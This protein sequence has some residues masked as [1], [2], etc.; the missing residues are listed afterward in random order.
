MPQITVTI[1]DRIAEA[2]THSIVCGRDD[3][4]LLIEHDAEWYGYSDKKIIIQS[5]YTDGTTETTS[6]TDYGAAVALPAQDDAYAILISYEGK[7]SGEPVT[8]TQIGIACTAAP[9]AEETTAEPGLSYFDVYNT[10]MEYI[11]FA[12]HGGATREQLE[13]MY[14]ALADHYEN[15][16][17]PEAFPSTAYRVAIA[18]PIR[19]VRLTG[20]ITLTDSTVVSIDSRSI[21]ED[22][23]RINAECMADDYILP[24]AAVAKELRLSLLGQDDPDKIAGARIVLDYEI[25]LLSGE[26]YTVPLGKFTVA[27]IE[28]AGDGEALPIVAYDD[29]YR[30]GQIE[31][32][33]FNAAAGSYY[34]PQQIFALCAL[35][36]GIPYT[37]DV[38]SYLNGN[39]EFEVAAL[40]ADVV[41]LRDLVMHTAQV[42]C[43]FAE[44]DRYGKLT[45]RPVN[46]ASS[47]VATIGKGQRTRTE[48]ERA[49]Y[50]LFNLTTTVSVRVDDTQQMFTIIAE[51]LR[52]K[53]IKAVMP[54]NPLYSVIKVNHP[55]DRPDVAYACLKN[56]VEN[57]IENIVYNPLSVTLYGD[58]AAELFERRT[59]TAHGKAYT[60]P[61]TAYEWAFNSHEGMTACGRDAIAG[62]ELTQLEKQQNAERITGAGEFF[63]NRR[64]Y[65]GMCI[66]F[67]G[68]SAMQTL[69]HFD[70]AKFTQGELSGTTPI[71]YDARGGHHVIKG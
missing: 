55:L 59:V 20:S 23:V 21:K 19:T 44:I 45:I 62:I 4:T 29:M 15:P 68:H 30:M 13:A 40:S 33:W 67:A 49:Q 35:Q 52:D 17:T 66:Q 14:Q 53:G 38:S 26:W 47:S 48:V 36:S 64:Q 39:Y 11:A 57:G 32:A 37:D 16:P 25:K 41:S 3:Y 50:E 1:T 2:D 58:P 61:V 24:G 5:V 69:T 54:E 18:A 70:L 28:S 12:L 51:T 22:S 43:S 8:S 7:H 56:I 6:I 60:V 10:M 46:A 42:V 9:E 71:E 31:I 63:N 27:T 34:T 65:I